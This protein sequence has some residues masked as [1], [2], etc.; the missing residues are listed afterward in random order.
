MNT[1]KLDALI[2]KISNHIS[3]SLKCN[4][5]IAIAETTKALAELITARASL[6]K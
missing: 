3:K 4:D 2:D 5:L 6:N 1:E